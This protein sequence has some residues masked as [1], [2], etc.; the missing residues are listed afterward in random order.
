MFVRGTFIFTAAAMVTVGAIGGTGYAAYAEKSD[1]YKAE[2]E[3]VARLTAENAAK[4]E[5]VAGLES[6]LQSQEIANGDLAGENAALR[7]ALAKANDKGFFENLGGYLDGG[8]DTAGNA[9]GAATSWVGGNLAPLGVGMAAGAAV[10][11][12]AG[13]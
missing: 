12:V 9:A 10:S 8:V 1:Q 7:D 13:T 6:A 4:D 5:K 11:C 2:K 3:M